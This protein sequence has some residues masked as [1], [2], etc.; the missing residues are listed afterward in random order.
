[1]ILFIIA[2]IFFGCLILA[3]STNEYSTANLL[4]VCFSV[5]FGI[6][7]L[8]SCCTAIIEYIDAEANYIKL[9]EKRTNLVYQL[10]NVKYENVIDLYRKELYD[11]INEFNTEVRKG[12]IY[13]HNIWVKMFYPV[14]YDSIELIELKGEN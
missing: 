13:H 4:G 1:M 6:A 5:I 8:I 14:D 12:R 2:I 3:Y 7:L 11:D 9:E 10:E